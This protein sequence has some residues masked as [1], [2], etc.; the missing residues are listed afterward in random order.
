MSAVEPCNVVDGTCVEQF[1]YDCEVVREREGCNSRRHGMK[2]S[3]I[4]RSSVLLINSES[5]ETHLANG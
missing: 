2:Q 4:E 5:L 1:V 3:Y